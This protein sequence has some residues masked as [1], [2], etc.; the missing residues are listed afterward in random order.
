[1]RATTWVVQ[2]GLSSSPS[3]AALKRAVAEVDRPLVEVRVTPF[4]DAMPDIPGD[5]PLPIVIYGMNT[6]IRNTSRHPK[7]K[8]GLFFHQAAF[9][10]IAYTRILGDRMLNA[11]A[12][13]LTCEQLA[14]S[15]FDDAETFFLRPNDDSKS[16]SGQVM[17]FGDYRRWYDTWEDDMD[18]KPDTYVLVSSL[19]TIIAE[20]RLFVLDGKVIASSQYLPEARRFVAPEVIDFAGQVASRYSPADAFV[21]DIA[22]TRDGLK[23]IEF[24]C[25]NGSGFYQ[26]DVLAIVRSLSIWQEASC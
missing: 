22:A 8:C 3:M 7:W 1:M 2:A 17:V 9:A 14:E 19:K 6:M 20:Y 11:D 18:L 5:V 21:C 26:A 10:P 12:E 23:V 13:L 24:N 15:G 16:F 4:S 25:I